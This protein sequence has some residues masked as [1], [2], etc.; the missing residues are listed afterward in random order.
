M[1]LHGDWR[2]LTAAPH[3]SRSSSVFNDVYTF[4]KHALRHQLHYLHNKTN[5]VLSISNSALFVH[6][7]KIA[8]PAW[9]VAC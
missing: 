2:I 5:A 8:V 9:K 7:S 6:H 1:S 3:K 4:D